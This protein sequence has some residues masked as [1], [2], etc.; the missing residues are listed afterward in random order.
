VASSAAVYGNPS[1]IPIIETDPTLPISPYGISKLAIERYVSAYSRLYGLKAASLRPFSAYGPR[2]RKQVVYD[3]IV[4][5]STDPSELTILGD[6]NQVRDFIFVDDI[7]QAALVVLEKSPLCGDVYNVAS[8]QGTSTQEI[9]EILAKAMGLR[10]KYHYTGSIRPGEPD[11]WIACIDK[12]RMLGFVPQVAL[13][14]GLKRTVEWY[15][16]IIG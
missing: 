11:K 12:L 16:S 2:L 13:E 9:A 7:V 8:G 1:N 10:P 15:N 3:F 6:G 5:L 14:E 4:K